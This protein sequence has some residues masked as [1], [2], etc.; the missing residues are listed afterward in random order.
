MRYVL[1]TGKIAKM[2]IF[3]TEFRVLRLT[4]ELNL[5]VE[6]ERFES[7]LRLGVAVMAAGLMVAIGVGLG[8]W[9]VG[10]TRRRRSGCE[11]RCP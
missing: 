5:C 3:S 4:F 10:G 9:G 7:E 8:G 6:G 11:S 2:Q 1:R